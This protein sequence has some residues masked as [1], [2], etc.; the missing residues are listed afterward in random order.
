MKINLK[1][2]LLLVGIPLIL[3]SPCALAH[4]DVTAEQ[5][6]ELIDSTDDL[7]VIDVRELSEYCDTKGH[8]PGALNYPWYSGVLE[9]QYGELPMDGPVL[10]VC[11]S[12]SRSNRAADFLDSED[13]SMVY[14]MLGGM[15]AWIW[16]TEPCV[17]P[18]SK[19]GGGTGEPNDP[20]QIATAED[21]ILLGETP[22]DYDK[23]FILTADIDLDPNLP[24]RKVFD[25]AVIAPDTNDVMRGFQ[26]SPFTG[27]FDGNDHMISHLT[28]TGGVYLGL[29][30]QLESEAIISNLG[31]EETDVNGIGEHIGSLVGW[32]EG[33][34]TMSY[35]TGTISGIGSSFGGLVGF[36]LGSITMSNST[37]AV[38]GT[39]SVGGLVGYNVGDLTGCHST[40]L[41]SGYLNV[42][43]LVGYSQ[44]GSIT[45]SYS[46]GT[47]T[48]D[49]SV[50][51]L[52][53]WNWSGVITQCYSSGTVTGNF[54]IGGLLGSDAEGHV[55][56]CYISGTV[57]GE[58]RVGGLM[59]YGVDNYV[60]NCFWDIQTSGQATSDGGSGRT[61]AEMQTAGTFL[62]AGWDFVDEIA[63][64]TEDIW[65]ICEGTNYPRFVW[66]IAAGD[67]VCPDGITIDD[68][69]FFMEHWL[70]DN[71]DLS[72]GYCQGTD[73]DQSG[74]VDIND[75][76]ILLE[77][78]LAEK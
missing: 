15:R 50:G 52:A 31:L 71:C 6:R 48:G 10:V 53:G 21:L 57:S 26:G 1:T 47:T 43:G 20:Y 24:G 19:Y 35:S 22:D 77:N 66:Q 2:V 42:G 72:N 60:T 51:G 55:T 16:E 44:N 29:F 65:S 62:E 74:T 58:S 27:V 46:S 14:D 34:I 56:H 67:F 54:D 41:V 7:I 59:G 70:D 11:G 45:T 17:D 40:A 64:G 33:N 3:S 38:S 30:G 4:T 73:L 63:N 68:F 76:E 49:S 9:A 61:T 39:I 5:A 23:H 32:N 12:G 25:R 8:I 69:S 78:W 13:F 36:N 37:C 28:V 75:L 18:D